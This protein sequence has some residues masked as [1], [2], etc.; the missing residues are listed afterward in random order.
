M[1][2]QMEESVDRCWAFNKAGQRCEMVAGH[3]R[4]H[5]VII[6]WGPDEC[7]TPGDTIEVTLK[8]YGA[9][10]FPTREEMTEHL[11]DVPKPSGKCV[12][13][14]HRMHAGPCTA[15]DGE[16]DCDCAAGIEE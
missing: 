8:E 13:C 15:M 4:D 16:F 5:S 10:R 11:V 1:F 3:D 14:S 9:P 2:E 12:I 7:W 6:A